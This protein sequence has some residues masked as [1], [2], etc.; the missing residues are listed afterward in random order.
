MGDWK[1]Q[2]IQDFGEITIG[3]LWI[4]VEDNKF[5]S[6]EKLIGRVFSLVVWKFYSEKFAATIFGLDSLIALQ[7]AIL[8][9]SEELQL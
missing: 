1:K 4:Q 7:L 2:Q 9:F 3:T 6:S 8:G 5:L